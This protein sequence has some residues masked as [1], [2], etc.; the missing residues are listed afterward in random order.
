[1][2]LADARLSGPAR[3]ALLRL[4]A[5]VCPPEIVELGLLEA[6]VDEVELNLRAFPAVARRGLVLGLLALDGASRLLRLDAGA[7]FDRLWRLPGPAHALAKG[8]KSLITMAYYEQAAVR[9]RLGYDQKAWIAEVAARRLERFGEEIR[10]HEAELVR[11]NPL[12]P[13][14]SKGHGAA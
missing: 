8:L 12:V 6:V 7:A 11:P 4:A 3:Q 13:K 10:R 1:M 5:A 2:I 14:G 9:A